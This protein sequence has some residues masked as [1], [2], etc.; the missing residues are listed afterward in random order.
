LPLAVLINQNSASASE[1]VA[2]C[3]QDN[4]R[5]TVVGQRSF[6]KG[7]V[8]R[9]LTVGARGT[10]RLKLTSATYWRPSGVN[11]HRM[12]GDTDDTKWGVVP[13]DGFEVQLTDDEY[14]AFRK[15]RS[16]RDLIQPDD[17]ASSNDHAESADDAETSDDGEFV[18]RALQRAVV[19]LQQQLGE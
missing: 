6:G 16:E 7:T 4:L 3:L 18:D 14:A 17:G 2:A 9:V 1:I 19:D 13:S 8:Q 15:H 10:S 5:A 12:P 11:I